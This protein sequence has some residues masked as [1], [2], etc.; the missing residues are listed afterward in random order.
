M[1]V[2]FFEVYAQTTKSP[3]ARVYPNAKVE[4][5][6]VEE[7][8]VKKPGSMEHAQTSQSITGTTCMDARGQEFTSGSAGYRNCVDNAN[9]IKK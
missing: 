3:N 7:R 5:Q 6:S 4:G 2:S 1:F 9:R 8:K